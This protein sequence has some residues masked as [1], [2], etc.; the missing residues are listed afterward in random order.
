VPGGARYSRRSAVHSL[1]AISAVQSGTAYTSEEDPH[2][3]RKES[4]RWSLSFTS[5]QTCEPGKGDV[6]ETVSGL[7]RHEKADEVGRIVTLLLRSNVSADFVEELSTELHRRFPWPSDHSLKPC[8][9]PA[10]RLAK[11]QRAATEG[12]HQELDIRG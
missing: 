9:H 12:E 8:H 11:V 7:T 4:K 5:C 10:L 3:K 2:Y 1:R 6:M